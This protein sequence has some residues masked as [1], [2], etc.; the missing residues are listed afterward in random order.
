LHLTSFITVGGGVL[1]AV[2]VLDVDVVLCDVV[3]VGAGWV[4]VALVVVDEDLVCELGLAPH[5]VRSARLVTRAMACARI[6]TKCRA[7]RHGR[8]DGWITLRSLPSLNAA[9]VGH[10]EASPLPRVTYT[11]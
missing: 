5:A 2:V 8:G 1:G 7:P 3:V 4:L 10:G 6:D 9:V 11:R